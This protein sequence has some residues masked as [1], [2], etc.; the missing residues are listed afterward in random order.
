M[1]LRAHLRERRAA[2][3]VKKVEGVGRSGSNTSACLPTTGCLGTRYPKARRMRIGLPDVRAS[4]SPTP[5][6]FT[7][8]L[9]HQFADQIAVR[10][11]RRR[12]D[13]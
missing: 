8:N 1:D 13:R 2:M 4:V 5:S 10:Q 7:L 12:F 9:G 6:D 11:P 3:Q